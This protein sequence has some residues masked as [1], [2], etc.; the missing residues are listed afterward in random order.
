MS[1][2]KWQS[3]AAR[4]FVG[5][6]LGAVLVVAGCSSPT[7]TGTVQSV[8]VTFSL[9][10]LT[11]GKPIDP[12]YTGTITVKLDSGKSVEAKVPVDTAKG[13]KGGEKVTVQQTSS[14]GWTVVGTPTP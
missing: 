14:G 13:L 4:L 6:L 11:S 12:T 7:Q 10:D 5:L 9:N 2:M 1:L 3:V 8:G